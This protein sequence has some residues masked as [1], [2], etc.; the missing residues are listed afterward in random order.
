MLD[1][2]RYRRN[3]LAYPA[4]VKPGFDPAHLAARGMQS[5]YGLAG[6]ASG[7][8]FIDLLSGRPGTIIGSISPVI[9]TIG[10][11]T[12]QTT[13]SGAPRITFS[14]K[15]AVASHTVT[16]AAI[17]RIMNGS[18]GTHGIFSDNTGGNCWIFS[19]S[20]FNA[21]LWIGGAGPYVISGATLTVGVPYFVAISSNK[22]T[23]NYVIVN[24]DTGATRSGTFAM[25][26]SLSASSGTYVLAKQSAEPMLGNVAAVMFS[27]SLLSLDQLRQWAKE[28][29]AF[30]YPRRGLLTLPAQFV[31][32]GAVYLDPTKLGT[33]IVLSNLNLTATQLAAATANT[34]AIA[35]HAS[36]KYYC[37]FTV[38][39]SGDMQVGL[40]NAATPLTEYL[41]ENNTHSIGVD[42][43]GG[44]WVGAGGTTT[45]PGLINGHTYG[46]AIDITSKKAW[47]KDITAGGLWN[48]DASANPVTGVNGATFTT[49]T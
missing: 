6:V 40:C 12:L 35:H 26:G 30:W 1:E 21:G 4:G 13:Q 2:L 33:N 29:W 41:G 46:L 37:E 44:G 8:N 24:L 15:A 18:T 42:D 5:A 25:T 43:G 10:P 16:V 36:G 34:R 22:L 14:A 32:L 23:N 28:P 19:T 45:A 9:D 11:C 27:P 17:F 47:L 31:P 3:L 48:N 38:D 39:V 20:S 7:G 49:I